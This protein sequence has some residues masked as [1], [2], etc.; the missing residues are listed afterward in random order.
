[1]QL[2]ETAC[3]PCI[4]YS[5]AA[6]KKLRESACEEEVKTSIPGQQLINLWKKIYE[7]QSGVDTQLLRL[8][9]L[10]SKGTKHTLIIKTHTKA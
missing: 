9:Q 6:H 5:C 3:F 4:S 10:A 7:W 2:L 8:H 1:M